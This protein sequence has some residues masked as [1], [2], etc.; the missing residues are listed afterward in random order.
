MATTSGSPVLGPRF[1]DALRFGFDA[2]AAQT[3]KG[4]RTPYVAHLLAVA[5][6]VIE[7]GGDEDTAIAA[8][9]HDAVEDQGGQAMLERIR[10]RF[11]DRVAGI[12]LEC[13]DAD[14]VP[15]PPWRARKE[16]YVAAIPHKSAEARL[17]SLAD[18]VHNAREILEDYRQDGEALWSRFNGGREGT[19]WYYRALADAYRGRTPPGL[20]RALEETVTELE[21]LAGAPRA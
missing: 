15:K 11:G 16:N 6:L 19:L 7:H 14:V 2:H 1:A 13:T 18:K 5:A 4:K 3:R 17:V 9:L 12:V 20:Y 21:R 8:L 10:G